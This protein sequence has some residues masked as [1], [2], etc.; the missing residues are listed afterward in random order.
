MA[1]KSTAK[2]PK[3]QNART[4]LARWPVVP[5]RILETGT[6]LDKSVTVNIGQDVEWIAQNGGGPWTITFDAGS[7]FSQSTYWV[8]RGGRVRTVGGAAGPHGKTYPYTVKDE[9]GVSR[10]KGE[11]VVV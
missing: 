8:P 2:K 1:K 3:A 6:V 5:I 11:I 7:P 10:G 9:A 4:P